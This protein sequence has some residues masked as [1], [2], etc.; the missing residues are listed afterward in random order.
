MRQK[1]SVLKHRSTLRLVGITL[2]AG[3][4]AGCGSDTSRFMYY[5]T[6][7]LTT[8]SVPAP[9]AQ[10]LQPVGAN[11]AALSQAY[12]GDSRQPALGRY[13]QTVTG[14][15][16]GGMSGSAARSAAS[17][18]DILGNAPVARAPLGAPVRHVTPQASAA[19]IPVGPATGAVTT[20]QS[21]AFPPAPAERSTANQT[22]SA[23]LAPAGSPDPVITGTTPPARGSDSRGWTTTGGT[24]ITLRQGETLYNLSKRYGVPVKE[25]MKANNISD[26]TR[27]QA[28]QQLVMP[29][30]VYSSGAPVSAPDADPQVRAARASRGRLGEADPNDVP[31]PSGAP[32]RQV[33]VLPASSS[34][35]DRPV[36]AGANSNTTGSDQKSGRVATGASGGQYV[37]QSGD[38]LSRIARQHGTDVVSLKQA[39]GL[40]NTVIRIG[41]TLIIPGAASGTAQASSRTADAPIKPDPVVTAAVTPKAGEPQGY[42]A[43]ETS[44]SLQETAKVDAGANAP[45]A[46]GIDKLRWPARGQVITGFA[47][48]E[49]GKRNDGIDLSLPVGTPIKAAE[50]GVVIYSGDGLKEYGNTVLVRHDDGLVTVYAHASKL[51]V[52]RGDKVQRGQV[53][54]A[55]GMSGAAKTP[56]LHFEVRK[57][58]TPV[59]PGTYLE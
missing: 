39:N 1:S 53:I 26:P 8:A 25:I 7:N 33:A 9:A 54:A 14:S 56:R 43:P 29:I 13:D 50:N 35:R 44:A 10:D 36:S 17:S 46:S 58:A 23:T 42:K 15:V 5:G 6:D 41:Q 40:S 48:S 49:D 28:G 20:D 45:K 34:L 30:F 55:S 38:T 37:V 22:S 2:L 24:G 51:N 57:N 32:E 3:T 18:S 47:K 16:P 11:S 52:Q 21:Q 27:V 4:A 19:R 31:A 59:N 12:P